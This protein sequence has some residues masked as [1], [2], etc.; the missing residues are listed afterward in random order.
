MSGLQI[1]GR[2]LRQTD[3]LKR[4]TMTIKKQAYNA[5]AFIFIGVGIGLLVKYFNQLTFNFEVSVFDMFALCV[6]V[7]LAWWVAEKLEKDSDRERCEK[8]IIIEKLKSMDELIVKLNEK[9]ESNTIMPLT[10]VTSFINSIDA[11]STRIMEQ[12]RNHYPSVINDHQDA[13]YTNELNQLDDLCTNDADGG[14]VSGIDNDVSVCI[15][16]PERVE[17]IGVYS[18]LLSDKIFNLEILVNRA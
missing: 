9:I 10:M 7:I 2:R 5:L 6:T 11:H 16:S 17:D 8:D 4:L 12:I 15:Y 1:Q 18:N 13:D 3:I 14:M